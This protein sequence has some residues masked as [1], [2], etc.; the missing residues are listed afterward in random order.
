NEDE[1]LQSVNESIRKN[2]MPAISVKPEVGRFLSL[3]VSIAKPRNIM[4]IGALGGYS[5][6]MLASALDKE[7]SLTS[8]ELEEA[9]ANVA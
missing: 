3:L 1:A 7:G 5:G 2:G 9:Y 4:E 6:I 8:L